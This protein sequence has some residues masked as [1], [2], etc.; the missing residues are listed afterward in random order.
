MDIQ[1]YSL[2]SKTIVPNPDDVS[3]LLEIIV[4]EVCLKYVCIGDELNCAKIRMF[5]FM[6]RWDN[7]QCL[8]HRLAAVIPTAKVFA[9]RES[10]QGK[11]K[12]RI[13]IAIRSI[14]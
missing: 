7:C 13:P 9:H 11:L 14:P 6:N 3:P 1:R 5:G 10:S 12:N 2:L 4:R 8:M